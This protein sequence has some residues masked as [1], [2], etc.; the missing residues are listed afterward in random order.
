MALLRLV[1]CDGFEVDLDQLF[2]SNPL[3]VKGGGAGVGGKAEQGV[4]GDAG[5]LCHAPAS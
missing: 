4:E 5:H 2:W 1:S 3:A